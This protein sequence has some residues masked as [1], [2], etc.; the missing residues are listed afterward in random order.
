MV[1]SNASEGERGVPYTGYVMAI[2][3]DVKYVKENDLVILDQYAMETI[4]VEGKDVYLIK[5]SRLKGV[6]EDV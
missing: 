5:E 1:L 4:Q 6:I 3:D 2:G